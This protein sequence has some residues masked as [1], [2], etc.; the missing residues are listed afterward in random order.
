MDNQSPFSSIK[1]RCR[2]PRP[3]VTPGYQVPTCDSPL[4][5]LVRNLEES[6]SPGIVRYPGRNVKFLEVSQAT[7]RVGSRPR[8]RFFWKDPWPVS[9]VL[10]RVIRTDRVQGYPPP[11]LWS[12]VPSYAQST[13]LWPQSEVVSRTKSLSLDVGRVRELS[14][15]CLLSTRRW[16]TTYSKGSESLT[17]PE[18]GTHPVESAVEKWFGK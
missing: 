10:R 8:R 4:L 2:I 9:P 15:H 6:S 17:H 16:T 7:S 12:P 1:F 11:L 13:S 18:P 14:T 3:Q 5:S